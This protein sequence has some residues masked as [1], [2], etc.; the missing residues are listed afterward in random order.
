MFGQI[1][2]TGISWYFRGVVPNLGNW[3]CTY[4]VSIYFNLTR[5]NIHIFLFVQSILLISVRMVVY[6]E[7][8][9][10]YS[11]GQRVDSCPIGV[12]VRCKAQN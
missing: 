3:S 6:G 5:M 4:Q 9:K 12:E 8:V 10:W 11:F 2:A 7:M 1:R